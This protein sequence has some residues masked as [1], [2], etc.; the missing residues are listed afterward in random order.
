MQLVAAA[1]AQWMGIIPDT[2]GGEMEGRVS[3]VLAPE[4]RQPAL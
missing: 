2:D 1:V 3:P 4:P